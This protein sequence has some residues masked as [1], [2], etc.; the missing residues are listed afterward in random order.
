MNLAPVRID[1][2]TQSYSVYFDDDWPALLAPYK[3]LKPVIITDR[4]VSGFHLAKWKEIIP[5]AE[6]LIIP[7]GDASKSPDMLDNIYTFLLERNYHRDTLII[8][9]GGGVVG[10]LAGYAAATFMRGVQLLQIPTSLLAMVDAAIGGKTGINHR[11]GKNLI[12]AFKQPAAV[13]IDFQHLNTLP[14]R[15]WLC[16]GGEILKYA[17][18]DDRLQIAS[19]LP[20]LILGSIEKTAPAVR[21]CVQIK[22]EIVSV[23]E[24]DNTGQR[25][26]LNF[27]HTLGHALEAAGE[28]ELF[29]HGEAAAA[30]MAGA[31]FLSHRQGLLNDISYKE[32]IGIIRQF[33]FPELKLNLPP[34]R[35]LELIRRDKKITGGKIKFVLVKDFGK[36][37]IQEL[38]EGVVISAIEFTLNFLRGKIGD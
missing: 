9:L 18:I 13:F 24:K 10:D 3:T 1:L 5:Q 20:G 38:E 6:V 33:P 22:A 15:E 28:Y 36:P 14:Q 31:C 12:G 25:A 29:R 8:A 27:G 26:V 21:T 37:V 19:F 16:G 4:N 32:M 30:G 35:L 7:P 11:L 23:D 2:G 34:L 17:F